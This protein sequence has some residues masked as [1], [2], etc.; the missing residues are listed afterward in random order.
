M[1]SPTADQI[2]RHWTSLFAAPAQ[3]TGLPALNRVIDVQIGR[4]RARIRSRGASLAERLRN[5]LR[6]LWVAG[7]EQQPD[8]VLDW[9]DCAAA[10]IPMPTLPWP[11]QQTSLDQDTSELRA[12][13]YVFTAHGDAVVTAMNVDERHTIGF[14]RDAAM[15]PLDHY[16]QALFITFYQHLR[17]LGLHLIHASAIAHDDRVILIAGGSGAGKTT[18]MLTCVQVGYKFLSDDAT[19]VE[20]DADGEPRAVALL[21]ALHITDQTLAWFPELAPHASAQASARGKRLV[22]IDD[23]YPGCVALE[24]KVSLILVPQITAQV[25]S[26]VH[27]VSRAQLLGD[28]LPYSLDLPD[29]AS[30][31]RQLN[32]LA[33]LL[34]TTPTFRLNLG[35]DRQ[36]LPALLSQILAQH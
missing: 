11:P 9:V 14:V 4:R 36:Q 35:Q 8:F 10:A 1:T 29:A 24:G 19:L 32:F 20:R 17:H 13:P 33:D 21:N 22:L 30:A 18:T 7:D 25:E 6:H 34:Q 27:Q 23:A 2:Y 31:Q 26:T 16:K 3:P 5:P 28:M 12:G 15:W